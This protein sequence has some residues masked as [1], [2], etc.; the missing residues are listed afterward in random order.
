M[1]DSFEKLSLDH[2]DLIDWSYTPERILEEASLIVQKNK[3]FNDQIAAITKP[4]I[5]NTL[6]PSIKYHNEHNIDDNQLGFFKYV[7]PDK[8]L[9]DASSK[10]E[11]LIR[12][13]VA[14]QA[15]REDVFKVYDELLREIK[16]KDIPIHAE[17]QKFLEQKVRSFHRNGL[18][19]SDDKLQRLKELKDEIVESSQKF[20]KNITEDSTSVSI[21]SSANLPK[22]ITERLPVEDGKYVLKGRAPYQ[23]LGSANDQE[24]RKQVFLAI[25]E[26][27]PGNVLELSKLVRLRYELAKL[28]GY[29]SYSDYALE[30]NV[31][32]TTEN[33]LGFLE[34][35]KSKIQLVAEKEYA[36]L[37]ELKN[38]DLIN[39]GIEP[40]SELFNWDIVYYG[41]KLDQKENTID[42]LKLKEYFPV[43]KTVEKMMRIYEQIFDMK[44]V[45]IKEPKK[46]YLWHEDVRIFAVYTNIKQGHPSNEFCGTLY[47]DLSSR[48]GKY[49]APAMFPIKDGYFEESLVPSYC[50]LVT[51]GTPPTESK[52]AFLRHSQVTQTFHELGHCIHLFLSRARHAKFQGPS[53]VPR[54]FLECPSQLLEFW[55]WSPQI[56]QTLSG[57]YETN[58]PLTD[59]IAAK[60]EK[61]KSLNCGNTYIKRIHNALF[62][63]KIHSISKKSELDAFDPVATWNELRRDLGI[64]SYEDGDKSFTTFGQ[65]SD[66]Y[67]STY[68][69]YLYG[70]SFAADIF[71]SKF[72]EDPLNVEAGLEYRQIVLSRG[73]T[74]D[75]EDILE[76]FLVRPPNSEAYERDLSISA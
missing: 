51:S 58:L 74:L 70:Q 44:F 46:K 19:L 27:S 24:I 42:Y 50:A 41:E 20:V 21:A 34:D 69:A 60:L 16:E 8:D 6:E 39:K 67:A 64:P 37:L 18:G 45:E 5:A 7:S 4:T 15:T 40:Q 31:A 54:D 59:E 55:T 26:K 62:D 25:N 76:E 66:H 52:P 65:L 43:Q 63:L 32:K 48:P 72:R 2:T 9:R 11:R 47:L 1:V 3:D 57:H 38:E 23:V 73:G 75:I 29:N 49:S 56:L 68:Y 14:D 13:A 12:S 36:T 33:A 61:S 35:L 53:G 30:E 17:S 71:Y 22:F 28:L 10:A